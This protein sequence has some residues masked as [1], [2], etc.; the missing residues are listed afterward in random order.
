MA[1]TISMGA[2]REVLSAAAERY[3]SAG[4]VEKGRIL[5]ALC[6][7]TG[8]H[9]KHAVR[10]LR[11]RVIDKSVQTIPS[12]RRKGRY[13]VVIKD[14]LTAL[15]EASD[16][17]CGKRL[18]VMIPT[19]VPA[20]A[21]HGRLQLSE[22]EQAQLLAVSAA[23]IDRMLGDVKVA[24]AGGRRR[25]AGFYSAI[26][27]EVPIRTFDDWKDPAPGY[28]EVDMVAHGGTSVAGSFIQTLTMVDVA[29]GWTEC[30]PLVTR[31]GN[32]VVDAIKRAQGL[33][34]WLLRGVDFD[35]DSAFMNEVVVPWCR[36][37]MLEVTRSRAY[38]KNDQAFVEQKNGAVVRR[39]MG[40]GRF[41][42]AET[43][44]VMAR[45]YAAARLYVN[46][47]QPSF[48]LK[49]KRRE[50]AKVI[51]RYH[52]PC[53]PYERALAH[54]MVTEAVKERLCA[55]YR[56]L[57][58]V[59]LLAEIRSAQDELG[60]RV[61]RR[62]GAALPNAAPGKN[63]LIVC[64]STPEPAVFVQRLG[65]KRTRGE[66]RATHRQPKR[67]YKKRIRMPSKLDQHAAVIE[68]W[69]AA[70]PQLTAIAITGRLARLHPDQ[71]S[72]KQ[73]STVQRL[74]RALRKSAAQRLLAEAM[75]VMH[76]SGVRSLGAVDC[77]GYGGPDPTTAPLPDPP[78]NIDPAD[79]LLM[80]AR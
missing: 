65:N 41:H 47:F 51:K 31:E 73:H 57:D 74:L 33:F 55:Q 16:R 36:G 8:W 46:F 68:N 71:F 30:L 52:A 64:R 37:Q 26:R 66:P 43:A 4:R 70:E 28:C 76:E 29:T 75:V 23:T 80:P 44:R 15:W 11:R 63:D 56:T 38:K 53:T 22:V 48:K 20:L 60:D 24:A 67:R 2:R 19:L 9:R 27:R 12:R 35:N 62:A 10:A 39:L 32:L 18:V 79:V 72:S 54:A 45:L 77:S 49:E 40:Y 25:R 1:G 21:R 59:A 14:A 34:P 42:G 5:D 7:T 50:G 58:P 69:L 61:D 6:R 17:V 3:G 78:L 13:G